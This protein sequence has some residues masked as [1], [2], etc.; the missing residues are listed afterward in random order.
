MSVDKIA[1]CS[2]WTLS[3]IKNYKSD[4]SSILSPGI[5]LIK[6]SFLFYL[7]FIFIIERIDC[8]SIGLVD[9][10]LWMCYILKPKCSPERGVS[11]FDSLEQIRDIVGLSY[12]DCWAEL[13]DVV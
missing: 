5:L 8:L 3:I 1:S 7:L 4:I 9:N 10:S 6:L 11:F 12:G 2:R 13:V